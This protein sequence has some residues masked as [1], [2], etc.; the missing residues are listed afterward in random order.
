MALRHAASNRFQ[1]FLKM[2]TLTD[3]GWNNFHQ[4]YF[5]QSN[6]TLSAGRVVSI[7][8]FKYELLTEQGELETELSGKLMYATQPENLPK[9][10]DWVFFM[11]YDTTGYVIDV[12]PR[13]N[14][15]SR[16]NPGN[17]TEKQVLA[18]NIDYALIVQGLDRD[19]NLMKL[20]RY[21]VQVGACGITPI[22]ILNKADLASDHDA[23]RLA[24]ARLMRDCRVHFCSTYTGLGMTE[25]SNHI[26]E[27]EKTYI[28]IG[29][30]GVGKSSLLNA[31]MS[32][33]VQKTES[34]SHSTSKGKHTTTRRD[35][36]Q[37][38]NGSLIIDT[39]GMREFGLTGE[40]EQPA[41]DLFPAIAQFAAS[42]HFAD[43][44]HMNEPGCAVTEAVASGDL[45]AQVY[46]GYLKLVK[47]QRR[48][49]IDAEDK[50][51]MEKQ[52]GKMTR[53]AKDHRRKY[54]Y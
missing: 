24:V 23:Y 50:K 27:K 30:S 9:V 31:L 18:A 20:E 14:A 54:K 48:F 25:M 5:M 42:C 44:K 49:T 17:R 2:T 36:F 11:K 35:L 52:F 32:V 12:F 51:R 13:A 47:E 7:K 1:I 45:D 19:F 22:V 37:L 10:G 15:L 38:P 16:K 40:G 46:H 28:L 39:P 4:Q 41:D 53:E 33:G 6:N 8:G 43:C 21:L 29:S 3:F 34:T 26:L